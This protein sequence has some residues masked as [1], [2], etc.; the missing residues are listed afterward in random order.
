[1]IRE[2]NIFRGNKYIFGKMYQKRKK[3][4]NGPPPGP[5]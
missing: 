4:F 2:K 3:N 1:M 5:G